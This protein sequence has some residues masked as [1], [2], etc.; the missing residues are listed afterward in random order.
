MF[1]IG[2]LVQT[3]IEAFTGVFQDFITTFL[4]GL[5]S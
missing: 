4:S 1:D 5:F 2:V 3:L